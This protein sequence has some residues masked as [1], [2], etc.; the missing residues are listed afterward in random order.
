MIT[1]DVSGQPVNK[2]DVVNLRSTYFNGI[3][4]VVDGDNNYIHLEV[5]EATW[6]RKA[7]E[8]FRVPHCFDRLAIRAKSYLRGVGD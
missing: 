4:R 8:R 2:G 3:A 1:T 5:L 7:G 6:D